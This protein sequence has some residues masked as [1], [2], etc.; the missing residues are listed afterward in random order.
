MKALLQGSATSAAKGLNVGVRTHAMRRHFGTHFAPQLG[1]P[2]VTFRT[3]AKRR[4]GL[5]HVNREV[6]CG[7]QL[8]GANLEEANHIATW[9]TRIEQTLCRAQAAGTVR[10][11]LLDAGLRGGALLQGERRCPRLYET[12]DTHR[13]LRLTWA[14]KQSR[15]SRLKSGVRFVVAATSIRRH[16]RRIRVPTPSKRACIT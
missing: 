5:V 11:R 13:E 9:V 7:K 3:T 2:D 8:G 14:L 16:S 12:A 1:W 4:S 6:R 10:R 15:T